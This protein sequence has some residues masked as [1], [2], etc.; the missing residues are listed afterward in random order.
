MIRSSLSKK[1]F[2]M[3]F[4]T[5]LTSY[6]LPET[7]FMLPI[8][9][10]TQCKGLLNVPSTLLRELTD[11]FHRCMQLLRTYTLGDKVISFEIKSDQSVNFNSINQ[12]VNFENPDMNIRFPVFSIHGNHDDPSG[13]LHDIEKFLFYFM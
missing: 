6:C 3:L 13:R 9:Q 5:M 2:N 12:T 4:G 8:H 10:R 1:Y 11:F 7:Y